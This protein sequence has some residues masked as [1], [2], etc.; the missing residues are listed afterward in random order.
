MLTADEVKTQ[1][2]PKG[3]ALEIVGTEVVMKERLT[4]HLPA[5]RE[6]RK[7]A[8]LEDYID[9]SARR[10]GRKEK[11]DSTE[12]EPEFPKKKSAKR[13]LKKQIKERLAAVE[14]KLSSYSAKPVASAEHPPAAAAHHTAPAATPVTNGSGASAPAAAPVVPELNPEYIPPAAVAAHHAAVAA[15]HRASM[16]FLGDPALMLSSSANSLKTS[17]DALLSKRSRKPNSQ[18]A[19]F[20]TGEDDGVAVQAK[21]S[22]KIQ[23]PRK[24][25]GGAAPV[26]PPPQLPVGLPGRAQR[27]HRRRRQRST[28]PSESRSESTVL[29]PALKQCLVLVKH[30]MKHQHAWPFNTPVDPV[31]LKIPDYFDFVKHPM[32][33][34][35]IR[36][37]LENGEYTSVD[38]FHSDMQLV[39]TNCFA[40]NKPGTDIAVMAEAV[41]EAYDTQF[42]KLKSGDFSASA[43]EQTMHELRSSMKAARE[44]LRQLNREKKAQASAGPAKPRGW[45]K[46]DNRPMTLDEKRALSNAINE[47]PGEHLGAVVQI[48]SERIP[49]LTKEAKGEEIEID[50]DALDAATLRHLERFVK[51]TQNKKL[52]TSSASLARSTDV[53]PAAPAPSTGGEET[54]TSKR[55]RDVERRLQEL[56]D[57]AAA[58]TRIGGFNKKRDPLIPDK[59]AQPAADKPEKAEASSSSSSSSSSDSDSSSSSDSD[60]EAKVKTEPPAETP[61]TSAPAV[62]APAAP[63]APHILAPVAAAPKEVVLHNTDAWASL[64]AAAP[65]SAP[66][67]ATSTAV[68]A[69]AGGE[70]ADAVWDAFKSKEKLNKQRE[71]EREELEER[72]RKE[73]EERDEERRREDERRRKAAEEEEARRAKA[74]AEAEAQAQRQREEQRAAEK[75]AREA[76][77]PKA[78]LTEQSN[79]MSLFEAEPA[80]ALK[81]TESAPKQGE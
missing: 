50:I 74:S 8:V 28:S 56:N 49:A 18:F 19:E 72:L 10:R 38:E 45:Q 52:K 53:A 15:G 5:K 55:I 75:Q 79:V 2:L 81:H 35:T 76:E 59:P 47:L 23:R 57:K 7:S 12:D 58:L 62:A 1:R 33:F 63:T 6:R 11:D 3:Y 39:F 70:A 71:K 16:P 13:E 24:S 34:S 27:S 42:T 21:P 69:V 77:A 41:K 44:E 31:A 43:I 20:E 36:G 40:Y 37:N 4:V 17:E 51:N 64:D 66:A 32:D 78:N 9:S 25:E 61:A 46:E 80:T 68:P 30:L 26:S 67:P 60:A 73:R 29:S 14:A 65:S 54:G 48:I 22:Y